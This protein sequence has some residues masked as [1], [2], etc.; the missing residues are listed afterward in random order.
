MNPSASSVVDTDQRPVVVQAG[1]DGHADRT[2]ET[3]DAAVL[4]EA[5]PLLQRMRAYLP[6]ADLEVVRRAYVV[7][8]NAHARQ[9]RSSG[10][11]YIRHP[12]AV[13]HILVDLK[14]DP[15]CVA[16]GLLHDV[17]EDTT[18]SVEDLRREFGD[19]IAR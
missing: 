3:V 12:F 17:P 11:P 9:R 1:A 13:A 10:E 18:V 8:H 19:E 4:A 16:A 14:L 2:S 15:A 5:D 6:D 7:A